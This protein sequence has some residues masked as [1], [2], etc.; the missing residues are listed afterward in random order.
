MRGKQLLAI[1]SAPRLFWPLGFFVI[2]FLLRPRLN[3]SEP[4]LD[5]FCL[6]FQRLRM[7]AAIP[8]KVLKITLCRNDCLTPGQ[9]PKQVAYHED[10]S[11]PVL[12]SGAQNN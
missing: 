8:V 5:L 1:E 6:F 2:G 4:S 9:L 10:K 12:V 7:R 11:F 3:V